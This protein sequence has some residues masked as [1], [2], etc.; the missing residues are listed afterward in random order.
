MAN[1]KNM[2]NAPRSERL[3]TVVARRRRVAPRD[4]YRPGLKACQDWKAALTRAYL[5]EIGAILVE[6]S[7]NVEAI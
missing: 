1:T 6:A 5:V 7:K 2:H 3:E 4:G